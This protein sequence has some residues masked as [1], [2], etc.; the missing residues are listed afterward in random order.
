[1]ELRMRAAPPPRWQ[2]RSRAER[3]RPLSDGAVSQWRGEARCDWQA[4]GRGAGGS[5][6]PLPARSPH[7]G[8]S[9]FSRSRG[10]RVAPGSPQPRPRDPPETPRAAMNEEYDVIVLGTGLTVRSSRRPLAPRACCGRP[11]PCPAPPP[12]PAPAADPLPHPSPSPAPLSFC[13]SIT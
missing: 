1:M 7:G 13:P 10:P 3:S 5:A 8:G 9:I 2:R 11:P 4:R 12:P 6:P